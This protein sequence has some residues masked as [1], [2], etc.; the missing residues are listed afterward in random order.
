MAFNVEDLSGLSLE[1]KRALL[2]Q[3]MEQQE[4][5]E[6]PEDFPLSFAQQR[7]WFLDQ[8]EPGSAVYN[9]PCAWRI[10]GRLDVQAFRESLNAIVVRHEVLRTTFEV[11]DGEPVQ[12]I[13]PAQALT[14]PLVDLR[15]HPPGECEAEVWRVLHDRAGIPFDLARGPM[16]DTLLLRL[17]AE[18][19]VWFWNVHHVAFDG[20]STKV[21]IDELRELYAAHVSGRE[22]HLPDLPIQYADFAVWQREWLQGEVL[23]EQLDY[24][25][26]TLNGA[27][28]TLDLPTDR[29]RPTVQSSA[30]ACYSFTI[31]GPV[32]EK[33]RA[34][35]LS[36]KTTL[37]MTTL[38]AFNAI[39]CRYSGQADISVGTPIAGRNRAEIEKLIGFFI[40]TLVLRTDLSGDPTFRELLHR[41]RRTALHA[42]D[43]QDLPF[44]KLVEV[45]HPE[46]SL[47]HH[48][49]IQVMFNYHNM[50][51]EDLHVPGLTLEPIYVN[52]GASKFDLSLTLSEGE[53]Q[54]IGM[55]T[56]NTDL[57]NISTIERF[58][59]HYRTLLEGLVARPDA[60]IS[61][62]SL[63]TADERAA[64]VA[65]WTD[66]AAEYREVR[67]MH[68]LFEEQVARTPDALALVYEDERLTYRELNAR[69][70]RFAHHL[71]ALGAGPD[72]R[73]GLYLEKSAAIL[74]AL[75]GILKASGAYVPLDP[76]Y[77]PQRVRLMLEEA[78]A[79]LLVTDAALAAELPNADALT[80]VRV[81]ADAD[82]IAAQPESNPP[83]RVVPHNLIYVLFTSGSTGR[84]KGVAV[85]HRNYLNYFQ[86]LLPKLNLR[87]GMHF[88]MVSTF[89]TDLGTIQFWAPLTTGGVTHIVAY[90]R[91]TD[92]EAM[93][94]YFRRHPIDV[95]K[96]VP[97]HY[98]ALQSVP[99]AEE[100]VPRHLVIFTGEASHW[101]TVAKVKALNPA[102]E[103][104]DHYGVTET[105]CATLVKVV[106]EELP[107]VR[108]ATLPLG[109]P[110]GNVRVYTLDRHLEPAPPGVPGE[111]CI[112]GAGVTRGYV[113]QPAL[114][115][116]RFVPDPFGPPGSRMYRTGDLAY[117]RDDGSL[118]L[119]GRMDFQI[120]IRGYRIE[121]GEIETLICEQPEVQDAV[122]LARE[123]EPGDKR[124]VAYVVPQPQH[125]A[126]FSV[127]TLRDLLR[128]RLPDYMVPTAF[129]TLE[130]IPLNPNG[131]VDRFKLP[132]PEYS[133]ME[134]GVTFVAPRTAAEEAIA[135]AWREVLGL[136]EVGVHD[137]FFDVGGE[138]FKAIRVVRKI[139]EGVGVMDLFKRPTIAELAELLASG[140]PKRDGLLHELTPP[141]PAHERKLS[142]ICVPYGG[143]SAITYMPL[144]ESLSKGTSLYAVQLPGHDASRPDEA[145][146]PVPEVARRCVD[147][148]QRDIT[149]PIAVYGHCVGAALALELAR[150]LEDAGVELAGVYLAGALPA[151][152][153]PGKLFEWWNRIFPAES[154]QANR[155]LYDGLRALG[156][157][158]EEMSQ[159]EVE[160]VIRGMRHDMREAE[161]FYTRAEADP[162]S[163]KIAAPVVC[164]VGEGDRATELY[165]ERFREWGLYSDDVRL[166]VIPRAGHYFLKHQPGELAAIVEAWRGAWQSERAPAPHSEGAAPQP[167]IAP[168]LKIFFIVIFGQI[169][170]LIGSGLTNFALGVWVYDRTGSITD[171]AH[172]QL[173]A[174]LPGI[175]ALPFAGAIADRWDRR[176]LMIVSDTIAACCTASLVILLWLGVLQIW[177]L[178]ILA[179]V[180][181]IATAIQTPAYMAAITQLVP[182]QYLGRA[183][184]L[185][186]FGA[187][188]AQMVAPLLG[189]GLVLIIGL[190][191]IVII[192][193]LTF[194]FAVGTLLAIRIPDTL[195]FREEESWWEEITG[196]WRFITKRPGFVAMV[197]FFTVLNY[198]LSLVLVLRTP[199]VLSMAEATTLGTALAL[200][201]AG[202][203][204]GGLI[205]GLW[206]GTQRRTEGMIGFSAL[207]G[208]SM[209]VMGLRPDPVYS[210]VA[211]FGMGLSLSILN[212]H[213]LALIQAKVGLELQ[214]R[215]I[216]MNQMLGWAMIPLGLLTAGPLVE[217]VFEP[218]INGP[219]A[220]SLGLIVGTGA[221]RGMGLLILV[222]GAL[223]VAVCALGYA[224]PRLRFMEDELPDAIPD[225]WVV[226]DKDALQEI[227]DQKMGS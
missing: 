18:E 202:L 58:V 225:A 90:E 47:S 16:V 215:V 188:A 79:R 12:V 150:Q 217:H 95:L 20:W 192:D 207:Y 107:E 83:L 190:P 184:G 78:D 48:P 224:Y 123:D 119:L 5:E 28:P 105:T 89:S 112:G 142:L 200:E 27:P 46:R 199:L 222:A 180:S 140:E 168:S 170:S 114:T 162:A 220:G 82:A 174:L 67:C 127:G 29:P 182:K 66:T 101:E 169:V 51:E 7:L 31:T 74:P 94:D 93:V 189:G 92:P 98:D 204:L 186:Q 191:G 223:M 145:P 109:Q 144:A 203:L 157:F 106:P 37:F 54:L 158:S 111:L 80:V 165:E 218:L 131:K 25:K 134:S 55:I 195:F 96:L 146:Q 56:Y 151:P 213:W 38:A 84:P 52:S 87:E 10:T 110:L 205:M 50:P 154:R 196:G 34:L 8:W 4:G 130:A 206:G 149:G 33:L 63:L 36:E 135:A 88:A 61:E 116:E 85:E 14:T 42:Y 156:G 198:L 159:E 178:F 99:N 175:L 153:L 60:P 193:L 9:I 120:K 64:L 132:A 166:A 160:L 143:G 43:H 128:E 139:G 62:L 97:S 167:A 69:A 163:A 11:R 129:V 21:L 76:L 32:V 53:G 39:L 194:L 133:R 73:V 22:P 35:S 6:E 161:D 2:A 100:I 41:V 3:L 30:G 68:Q 115:A 17:D 108:A 59:A 152:R 72:V 70:N 201:G 176:K 221:G 13:A 91:A 75:L 113:D 81:D 179:G 164:I 44:E 219:L 216:S 138:S 177:H 171:L 141:M 26:R 77:P 65:G 173:F 210:I 122:V 212:A 40:N 104:Q 172:I 183:N 136:E 187:A 211:L 227:I 103:V 148:I 185:I 19:Y 23:Q 102:C 15:D 121:A 181:S 226:K 155:W 49:L 45:L 197:F 71:Q 208:L 57:F 86:G 147:E 125:A 118:K 124:L 214:G 209:V 1:E 117:F 137:N 24:W 126:A